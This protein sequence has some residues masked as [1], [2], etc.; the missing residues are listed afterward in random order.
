MRHNFIYF[1][2]RL[3]QLK[4]SKKSNKQPKNKFIHVD[5]KHVRRCANSV[6]NLKNP[7][8]SS[9]INKIA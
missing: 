8:F 7:I 2:N 6:T 5:E 1:K 3:D 4:K 9:R